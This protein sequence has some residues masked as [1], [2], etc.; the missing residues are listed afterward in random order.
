MYGML[1]ILKQDWNFES[2]PYKVLV[3][4]MLLYA[5]ETWALL[6]QQMQRLELTK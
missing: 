3:Q 5:S 1:T 2:S 4:S 6:K